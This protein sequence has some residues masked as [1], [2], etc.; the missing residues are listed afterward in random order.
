[1]RIQDYKSEYRGVQ[2]ELICK[3][4]GGVHGYIKESMRIGDDIKKY[5]PIHWI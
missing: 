2:V 3:Y 4:T 5:R 1:M